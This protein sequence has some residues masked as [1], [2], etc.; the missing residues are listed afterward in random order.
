MARPAGL[1]ARLVDSGRLS[2]YVASRHVSPIWAKSDG[3]SR[4]LA[5]VNPLTYMWIY[6]A[7]FT[8][9]GRLDVNATPNFHI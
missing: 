9:S 3:A 5:M 8:F 2:K 1:P 6:S 7:P 4:D